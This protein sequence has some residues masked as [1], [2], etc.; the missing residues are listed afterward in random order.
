M[1]YTCTSAL[2][3]SVTASSVPLGLNASPP[4]WPVS[5]FESVEVRSGTLYT[6]TTPEIVPTASLVPA[7]LKATPSGTPPSVTALINVSAPPLVTEYSATLFGPPSPTT[8][9]YDVAPALAK[10]TAT[11][12]PIWPFATVVRFVAPRAVIVPLPGSTLNIV[13]EP[14]KKL[15]VASS[16]PFGLSAAVQALV[17]VDGAANGDPVIG[18]Y[19]GPA[20]AGD[21]P[22]AQSAQAIMSARQVRTG[23]MM[24][25]RLGSGS[26][27]RC[28]RSA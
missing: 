19:A 27:V 28:R 6:W 18:V 9:R 11:G 26:C 10:A 16:V 23:I 20:S 3:N 14:P 7:E 17:E 24:R 1:V 21:A 25:A 4:A 22:T 8:A 13:T 5:V 12:L 15:G 2:S